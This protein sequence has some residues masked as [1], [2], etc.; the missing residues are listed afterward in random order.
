MQRGVA[1][2]KMH[3]P[4]F[5]LTAEIESLKRELQDS[6]YPLCI[7]VRRDH[8]LA[9]ALREA[10]KKRFDPRKYLKVMT[11]DSTVSNLFNIGDFCWRGCN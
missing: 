1:N 5:S 2:N 6:E 7:N 10:R 11:V 4:I 3:L 8:L 9:D